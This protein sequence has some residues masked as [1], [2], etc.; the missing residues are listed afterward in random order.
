MAIWKS[1]MRTAGWRI[2]RKKIITVIDATFAVAKRN[3]LPAWIFFRLSFPSCR[4]CVYKC[5]NLLSWF[6][7]SI[8]KNA[9]PVSRR[10]KV[11]IP[12]K[13]EFFQ[14]FISQ[15]ETV[16]L[17]CDD[18]LSNNISGNLTMVREK[19]FPSIKTRLSTKTFLWKWVLFAWTLQLASLSGRGLGQLGNSLLARAHPAFGQ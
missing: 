18:L 14:A 7:S 11:Q 10:S 1:Y 12:Y 16:R 3:P 5:D 4:S 9:A 8:T 6:I 17:N 15:L 19:P 2:I 13:P